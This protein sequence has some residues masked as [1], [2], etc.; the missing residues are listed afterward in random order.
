MGSSVGGGIVSEGLI[1]R[2]A[3]A[4]LC[5]HNRGLRELGFKSLVRDKPDVHDMVTWRRYA[6]AVVG[7]LDLTDEDVKPDR[8]VISSWVFDEALRQA[9]EDAWGEGHEAGWK[10]RDEGFDT[11]VNPHS[12]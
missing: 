7:E 11:R 10:D 6:R 5:E 2:I 9:R 4:I 3:E 12:L 1:N 8:V